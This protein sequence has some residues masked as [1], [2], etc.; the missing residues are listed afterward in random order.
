MLKRSSARNQ[1]SE[2]KS[3]WHRRQSRGRGAWRMRKRDLAARRGRG[4][5]N[6]ARTLSKKEA[7][8][9][10]VQQLIKFGAVATLVGYFARRLRLA[11]S[12]VAVAAVFAGWYFIGYFQMRHPPETQVGLVAPAK[13]PPSPPSRSIAGDAGQNP[14]VVATTSSSRNDDLPSASAKAPARSRAIL[15]ARDPLLDS[16]FINSYLR[17]WTPPATLPSGEQ[18]AAQIRIVHNLDG[19]IASA[20]VLVNPPSNPE[21]RVFANS[22]VRAVTKCNPLKVPPQYLDH[23]DQWKKMS[24]H[25]SPDSALE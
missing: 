25:F 12:V 20:P 4:A 6:R 21:W 7:N 1:Q 15:A 8:S 11:G 9:N 14:H 10:A 24:L 18:Y 2:V 22:A 13:S 16:W 17:C 23:F 5:D 19:S 3:I